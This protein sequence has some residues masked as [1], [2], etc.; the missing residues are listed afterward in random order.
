MFTT[1]QQIDLD[2]VFDT[3]YAEASYLLVTVIRAIRASTLSSASKDH[4]LNVVK[5]ELDHAASIEA[6]RD[7]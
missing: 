2:T 4:M 6:S 3:P 7:V 1:D 5:T